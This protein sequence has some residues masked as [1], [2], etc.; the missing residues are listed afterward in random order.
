M[1]SVLLSVC[2]SV[3]NGEDKIRNCLDSVISQEINDL[4]IILV[5]DGSEDDSLRIMQDYNAEHP[6]IQ[7]KIIDHVHT[8][9]AQGR[10]TGVKNSSGEY[11]TFLDVDDYLLEGAYKTILDF[12]EKTK[13]DIYEFQTIRD[14][15]YA[16]SS[17]TGVKNARDVL[18]D[19]FNGVG[20]PVNYWLRWFKRELL[21][22]SIFPVGI[23]LHED[24]YAFPCII[25]N[26]S[27]IAY[28]DKPLHVHTKNE[29]SIMGNLYA[30]RRG[31]EYFEK[32]KTLLRSIPHIVSNIGKDVI[33]RDY[34][35][36]F[37]N[38]VIRLYLEYLFMDVDGVSYEEKVDAIIDTLNLG[39]SRNEL[40]SYIRKNVKLNCRMNYTIR[41]LGLE[42]AYK[43]LRLKT[44]V[45]GINR[46]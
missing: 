27:T 39:M 15:Y 13:A 12:M 21:T 41:T 1:S 32:Q 18:K 2:I 35:A 45:S 26:A 24:V 36:S 6:E 4:E 29:T 40:E 38:Y 34:K 25:N 44:R 3:Y 22:E 8:G 9:L 28:I 31:R 11:I 19:Y 7:I 37:K 16:K 20:M 23:S 42:N 30:D 10:L 43:L 17:Y 5:N 33:E 14:G 46:G